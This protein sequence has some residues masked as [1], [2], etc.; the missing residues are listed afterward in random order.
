MDPLAKYASYLE[1]WY[2]KPFGDLP[3]LLF[4]RTLDSDRLRLYPQLSAPK[5][6]NWSIRIDGLQVGEVGPKGG[7]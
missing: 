6:G 7:A 3:G 4:S 1:E 5:T 2:P